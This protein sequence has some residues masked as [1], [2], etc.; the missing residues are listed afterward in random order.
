[1]SVEVKEHGLENPLVPQKARIIK[2]VQETPDVKT[3]H[4]TSK[5]GK[6][7]QCG[8]GQLAM[9][10]LLQVGEAMFSITSQGEDYLEFSIKKTGLLTD[11]LHEVEE[12]HVVGIR[13]PYGNGFPLEMIQ[14]KDL[15]FIAG[16]IGLAPVRSLIN[17]CLQNRK[18]YGTLQLIYG[19]RSPSDLCF[20]QDIFHLW[21]EQGLDIQVTVD[22]GD[23]D[24]Q[25]SI[26]FVPAFLK[27]LQPKP[28]GKIVVLCGPPLMIRF[29]MESLD[30]MGFEHDKI[31][32]TL[33][34]RMKCGIGKCGRCNIGSLY[35]CMDGPV[36]TLAEL[37]GMPLEL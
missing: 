35:V 29:V 22:Q 4:V 37:E 23:Q 20:K 1:M 14:G 2:I 10:S 28:P 3:F 9:L 31:I 25:G 6:P 5:Q 36:F 11:A 17:Y 30:E 13:G 7:F 12:G 34:K 19:A 18:D 24:W 15:L 27:E 33:E 32:T 21:P 8:P 16:G 26:G